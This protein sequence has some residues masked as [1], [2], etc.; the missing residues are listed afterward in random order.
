MKLLTITAAIL[1]GFTGL[2]MAQR[3]NGNF[4][5]ARKAAE[6]ALNKAKEAFK[7]G[8]PELPDEIQAQKDS[9][10]EER[11]LLREA[12]KAEIAALGKDATRDQLKEVVANF[13]VVNAPLIEAQ[14]EAAEAL[15]DAAKEARDAQ[16]ENAP[17]KV[18]DLRNILSQSRQKKKAAHEALG[19]AIAAA[20]TE[21]KRKA[22]IDEHKA[23]QRDLHKQVRDEL[24]KLR[25]EIR[26][27]RNENDR[28]D[29]E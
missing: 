15:R 14:R 18:K 26:N 27:A 22:L 2:A 3:G 6:E 13:K 20:E 4:D 24:K 7:N 19:R 1:F 25:E 11:R 16:L 8:R 23:E 28:R 5:N 12:L 10:D 21:E 29:A 17:D 9:Y